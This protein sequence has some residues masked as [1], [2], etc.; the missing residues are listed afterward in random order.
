[1]IEFT[2][3]IPNE[4]KFFV[5]VLMMIRKRVSGELASL[6]SGSKCSI[7]TSRVR[8]LAM[9]FSAFINGETNYS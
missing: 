2:Y 5:A 4:E 8:P 9:L 6:L 7:I 3:E 1:M